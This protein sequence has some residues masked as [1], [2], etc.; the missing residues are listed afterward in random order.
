MDKLYLVFPDMVGKKNSLWLF[1]VA[2]ENVFYI[3]LSN[4][5]FQ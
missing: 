2:S 5:C 4:L 3:V 1:I